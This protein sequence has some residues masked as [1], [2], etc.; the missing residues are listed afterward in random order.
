MIDE[1]IK[2]QKKDIKLDEG[3]LRVNIRDKNNILDLLL[4]STGEL[5]NKFKK[6][7]ES[8]TSIVRMVKNNNS[9]F[10]NDFFFV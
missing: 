7:R 5:K 6:E 3:N 4:L 8:S 10:P 1:S 2:I 9:K